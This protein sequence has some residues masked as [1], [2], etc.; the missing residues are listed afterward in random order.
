MFR[1]AANTSLDLKAAET[2]PYLLPR[3]MDKFHLHDVTHLQ[4]MV[5]RAEIRALHNP[6]RPARYWPKHRYGVTML[7]VLKTAV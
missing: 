6:C 7:T 4:G 1:Q 3:L 2:T 5:L